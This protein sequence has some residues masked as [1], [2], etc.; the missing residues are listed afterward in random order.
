[1]VKVLAFLLTFFVS[2]LH[3]QQGNADSSLAAG[4]ARQLYN[5]R[6]G[7][8][9]PVYTGVQFYPYSSGIEGNAY[10]GS[11]DWYRGSVIYEGRLY[12]DISMQYDLVKDQLVITPDEQGGVFISLFGPRVKEFSLAGTRFVRLDKNEPIAEGFYQLLVDGVIS[13]WAKKEKVIREKITGSSISRSFEEKV[14][15]Y[16]LRDGHY[17]AI[18]NAGDLFTVLREYKK[19][20][21]QHLTAQNLKYRDDPERTIVAAINFY[22]QRRN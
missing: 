6:M 13:G 19:E 15:Y 14:R 11:P 8:E 1:M 18:R 17:H 4:F 12:E 10:W 3:A 22:N 7:N 2:G 9:L 16:A 20:V 21:Q 5:T